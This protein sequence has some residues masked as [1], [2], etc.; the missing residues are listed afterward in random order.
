[1]TIRIALRNL[2]HDRIR[3]A[4]TLTGVIFA[5]VLIAVQSG[6]F[7][8]FTTATSCVIEN[9]EADVWVASRACATSTSPTLA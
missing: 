5:V 1:M 3:L 4:V 8:G 9:T 6:L 7:V 2:M